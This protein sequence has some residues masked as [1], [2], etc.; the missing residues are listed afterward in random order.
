M[1][2]VGPIHLLGPVGPIHLLGPVGA[3]HLL[4]PVGAIHF[5]SVLMKNDIW[6]M[7]F[8]RRSF[9]DHILE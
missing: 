2:P 8:F 3:I 7:S 5:Q 4:G 9:L 6:D 1:G